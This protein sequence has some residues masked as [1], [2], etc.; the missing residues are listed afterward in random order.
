MSVR[1]TTNVGNVFPAPL[2]NPKISINFIN[3]KNWRPRKLLEDSWSLDLDDPFPPF[4]Y[5]VQYFSKAN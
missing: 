1:V 5:W 3:K 2:L 4:L